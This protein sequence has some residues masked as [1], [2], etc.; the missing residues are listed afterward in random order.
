MSTSFRLRHEAAWH[1]ARVDMR[2][3]TNRMKSRK[4]ERAISSNIILEA[5]RLLFFC[6]RACTLAP[7]FVRGIW[8]ARSKDQTVLPGGVNKYNA[9]AAHVAR[10]FNRRLLLKRK[11]PS[12]SREEP[13]F[14]VENRKFILTPDDCLLC[15]S[16]YLQIFLAGR[17]RFHLDPFVVSRLWGTSAITFAKTWTDIDTTTNKVLRHRH[18]NM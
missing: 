13:V 4:G 6:D 14:R 7:Y 18:T 8:A 15:R 10:S 1:P 5:N 16:S 3:S 2:G 11:L 17:Q 12:R 9:F